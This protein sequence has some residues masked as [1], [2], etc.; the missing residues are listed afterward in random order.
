M[1]HLLDLDELD[2]GGFDALL[3]RAQAHLESAVSPD[4]AHASAVLATLFLEP[5]T[6]TRISMELAAKRLGLTVVNLDGSG[7]SRT[8][9]ETDTDTLRTLRAQ[10]VDLFAVRTAEPGQPLALAQSLDADGHLINCGEAHL[11]HPTQGLLDALTLRQQRPDPTASRVLI[12]GDLAHS[13]VARSA[14]QAFRLLGVNDIALAAPAALMP[15]DAAFDGLER[16]DRLDQA[17]PGRDVIMMLRIQLERMGSDVAPDAATYHHDWGLDG[18]RLA[19]AS[20]AAIVMHPGPF[21][22]EVEIS[23]SVADGP[24]SVIWQQVRNG[25]AVRMAVIERL[26]ASTDG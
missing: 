13:R 5:S 10:G 24:Q 7:S 25:V 16:F 3:E 8:K 17:L 18:A 23:T 4:P 20:D 26:L 11:N 2:R 22:R 21:N 14:V 9:G 12:V 15:C 19:L 6:R 1:R